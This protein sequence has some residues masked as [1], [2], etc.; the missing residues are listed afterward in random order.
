VA[1]PQCVPYPTRDSY[2]FMKTSKFVVQLCK[3]AFTGSYSGPYAAGFC[4]LLEALAL[5]P[6][7]ARLPPMALRQPTISLSARQAIPL[8]RR[9]SHSL[10]APMFPQPAPNYKSIGLCI[11]VLISRGTGGGRSWM[12]PFSGLTIVLIRRER[13]AWSA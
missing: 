8:L 13:C 5:S 12:V 1:R 11:R 2:I 7:V 4:S 6:T 9:P 10:H 3:S